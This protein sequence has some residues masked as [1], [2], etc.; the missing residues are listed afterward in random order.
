[1]LLHILPKLPKIFLNYVSIICFQDYVS[2]I[3]FIL[4]SLYANHMLFFKDTYY[5]FQYLFKKS[6]SLGFGFSFNF[7]S[8]YELIMF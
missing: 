5:I 6:Q 3:S 8:A 2:I 7:V 1:M 4:D